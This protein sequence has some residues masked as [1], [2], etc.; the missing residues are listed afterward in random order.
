LRSQRHSLDWQRVR[1][2]AL[3]WPAAPSRL[4]RRA[5]RRTRPR[6]GAL[7]RAGRGGPCRGGA[8]VSTERPLMRIGIDLGTTN[9]ALAIAGDEGVLDFAVAQLVAPGELAPR[10]VLPSFLYLPL[11]PE[12]PPGAIAVPWDPAR[13][14]CTGELARVQGAQVPGR[15]V[16]SAKSW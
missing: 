14:Y 8:S 6:W 15:L 10:P 1:A 13:A 2:A 9:S 16:A 3:S 7:A 5:H 11:G 4:A 12:L